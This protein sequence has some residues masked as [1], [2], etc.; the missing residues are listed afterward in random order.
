MSNSTPSFNPVVELAVPGKLEKGESQND[1]QGGLGAD[2]EKNLDMVVE[3]AAGKGFAAT[4]AVNQDALAKSSTSF[5][6]L[7]SGAGAGGLLEMVTIGIGFLQNLSIA[8]G[9][10][11]PWPE[12]FELMFTWLEI[13]SLDFSMFGGAQL[14]VWTSIWTGLLVRE[15][16]F[17]T[18]LMPLPV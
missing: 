3:K 12:S 17:G 14:G 15:R 2:L 16:S 10:P 18:G 1:F 13:F 8:M 7:M 6:T 5:A 4:D 11:I 9:I